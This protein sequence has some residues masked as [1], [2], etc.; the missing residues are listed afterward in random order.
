MASL[1]RQ[2]FGEAQNHV[3][4]D[5]G[6]LTPIDYFSDRQ[7]SL[8]IWSYISLIILN[9]MMLQPARK[10]NYLHGGGVVRFID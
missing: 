10:G 3:K 8:D 6:I 5:T 9:S 1:V 4:W 2:P 7:Y